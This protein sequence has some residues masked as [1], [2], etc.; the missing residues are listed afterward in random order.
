MS[1]STANKAAIREAV[2]EQIA[3]MPLNIIVDQPTNTTVNHLE[4]QCA[5]LA[6]SVK[7]TKWGSRHRCLALVINDEELQSITGNDTTTTDRLDTPARTLDG[8]T[9]SITLIN[10]TKRNVKHKIEQE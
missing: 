2:R 5:K 3:T 6:A 10:Q 7:T 9:N 1:S 4:Q 8:L